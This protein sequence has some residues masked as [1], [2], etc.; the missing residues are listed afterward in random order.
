MYG[1]DNL[2]IVDKHKYLWVILDEHLDYDTIALVMAG[3]GVRAV[4]SEKIL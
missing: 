4:H 1:I 2:D 3:S